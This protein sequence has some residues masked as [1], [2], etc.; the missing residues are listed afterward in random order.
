MGV[1]VFLVAMKV[2]VPVPFTF[3][4]VG[5]LMNEVMA[6]EKILIRENVTGICLPDDGPVFAK[7]DHAV[8][9]LLRQM[10]V[11]GGHEHCFAIL[12]QGE[13][14]INQLS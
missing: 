11:M 5:M 4:D 9:Y 12:P 8:C 7:H 6:R 10:H 14:D 3:V 13:K 1:V 2:R